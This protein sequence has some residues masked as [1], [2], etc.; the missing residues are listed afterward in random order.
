MR[1]SAPSKGRPILYTAPGSDKMSGVV[2]K[3]CRNKQA[4]RL[5]ET[6]YLQIRLLAGPTPPP[7]GYPSLLQLGGSLDLILTQMRAPGPPFLLAPR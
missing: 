7:Y 3:N 4:G 6:P 5:R 2:I 1:P